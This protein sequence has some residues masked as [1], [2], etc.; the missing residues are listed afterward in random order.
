[1][2]RSRVRKMASIELRSSALLSTS[3]LSAC[4][5]AQ[6]VVLFAIAWLAL[7]GWT[8]ES[9]PDALAPNAPGLE[10]RRQFSRSSEELWNEVHALVSEL[11]LAAA[12][13]NAHDGVLI[14]AWTK[15]SRPE[16]RPALPSE[17]S[18]SHV[19]RGIYQLHIFVPRLAKPAVV[20]VNALLRFERGD[21]TSRT[22][23][24][25]GSVERWLLD[26]LEQRLGEKGLLFDPARSSCAVQS[27]PMTLDEALA[28]GGPSGFVPP[29]VLHREVL[30][31]P[32]ADVRAG[33]SGK[34]IVQATVD[35]LGTVTA[36]RVRGRP[37]GE[38]L[39][40]AALLAVPFSRYRPASLNGCPVAVYVNETVNFKVR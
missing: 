34:V 31:Y 21:G 37:T 23:I 25:E 15:L 3:S 14:T 26:R 32:E 6:R 8:Q 28:A 9:Q 4:A 12:K 30:L 16:N 35:E 5:T 29:Q 17:L 11:K 2:R 7:P 18:K 39:R 24:D 22:T 27:E 13:E 38:Q 40:A 33:N 19:K 1:M 10:Y 36:V 20:Q